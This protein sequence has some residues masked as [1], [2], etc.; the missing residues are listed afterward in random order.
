M[1]L[2]P[3]R[4]SRTLDLHDVQEY[5]VSNH[6]KEAI[7]FRFGGVVTLVTSFTYA[8]LG[9]LERLANDEFR[10]SG[11]GNSS[12]TSNTSGGVIIAEDLTR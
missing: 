5:Y 8:L 6:A 9:F 3:G 4:C 12:N 1:A 2:S 7:G 10:E 11:S